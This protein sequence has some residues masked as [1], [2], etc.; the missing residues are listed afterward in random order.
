MQGWCDHLAGPLLIHPTSNCQ[1]LPTD[2]I[3]VT[4]LPKTCVLMEE[5]DTYG[6]SQWESTGSKL[7][8]KHYRSFG[9]KKN[10]TRG[11]SGSPIFKIIQHYQ[12]LGGIEDKTQTSTTK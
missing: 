1:K 12:H 6:L 7:V 11:N 4:S 10:K 2:L 5:K 9:K 3:K 8:Q